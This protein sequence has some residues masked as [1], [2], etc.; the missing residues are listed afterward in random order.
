MKKLRRLLV[1]SALGG[2][3]MILPGAI[4]LGL[5]SWLFSLIS[6]MLT[7]LSAQIAGS[8]HVILPAA[9]LI[10]IVLVL[11]VCLLLG[12]MVRTTIGSW[13]LE[14]LESRFLRLVPG[15][16]LTKETVTQLLG[17]GRA[18]FSQVALIDPFGNG[19]LLTGF[20]T[21]HHPDGW[22]SVFVPSSPNPTSGF[23][24]HLPPE[25]VQRVDVPVETAMRTII[26]AGSGSA[27]LRN[28]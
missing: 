25:R 4:L 14:T 17:N 9:H 22:L 2:L 15:Y 19:T 16:G 18:P 1:T 7:P 26:G 11:L 5:F 20:I 27:R 24:Y 6:S 12:L 21:E 23:V 13:L 3:L 10:V 28:F 8:W